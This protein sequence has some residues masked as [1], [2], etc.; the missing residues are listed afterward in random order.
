MLCGSVATVATRPRWLYA[1]DTVR[2]PAR[3]RVCD[4]APSAATTRRAWIARAAAAAPPAGTSV[5]GTAEVA[6]V[7]PGDCL[8][9]SS[10]REP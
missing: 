1:C 4:R 2:S 8:R 7:V 9:L 5:A 6:G 3:R 10:A